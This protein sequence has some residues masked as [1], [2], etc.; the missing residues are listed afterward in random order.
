MTEDIYAKPDFTKKIRFQTE[1]KEDSNPDVH[2]DIDDVRIYDN[3]CAEEITPPER[4]QDTTTKEQQQSLNHNLTLKATRL[5]DEKDHL[6]AAN[7]NLTKER[8]ELQKLVDGE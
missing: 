8:D 2:H 1:V 4:S 6:E 5:E 7:Y 3:Y